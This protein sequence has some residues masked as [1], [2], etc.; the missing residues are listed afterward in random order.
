MSNKTCVGCRYMLHKDT[1]EVCTHT[2]ETNTGYGMRKRKSMFP[3]GFLSIITAKLA[4]SKT[5]VFTRTK[6]QKNIAPDLPTK[7]AN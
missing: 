6:P 5:V 3:Q 4:L 2:P 7:T 1:F